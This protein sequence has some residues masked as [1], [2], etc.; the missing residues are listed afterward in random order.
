MKPSTHFCTRETFV[1]DNEKKRQEYE[2]KRK[3]YLELH[4]PI[5]IGSNNGIRSLDIGNR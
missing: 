3:E 5:R 1:K 4:P 2:R